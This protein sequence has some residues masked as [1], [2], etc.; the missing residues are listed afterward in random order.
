MR[1]K[2]LSTLAVAVLAVGAAA[3]VPLTASAAEDCRTIPVNAD[4][5][6]TSD[7][8]RADF[9]VDGTGIKVGIISGSFNLVDTGSTWEQ[10][11]AQGLL[12][13]E[14]NPC[15]WTT[16]VVRLSEPDTNVVPAS[17]ITDEGRAMAQVV[18]GIAPGAEL[19]YAEGVGQG[20]AQ[21]IQQLR[22][23]GVDIIV[24]DLIAADETV[25]QVSAQTAAIEEAVASGVTYLTAAG[26]NT[27]VSLERRRTGNELVPIGNWETVAYRPAPCDPS[28]KVTVTAPFTGYDC[29]DFD[30]TEGVRT[31][32]SLV[33][34]PAEL[35]EPETVAQPTVIMQWAEP[36]GAA[37][38]AFSIV[39]TG[40]TADGTVIASD[41]TYPAAAGRI[42]INVPPIVRDD[43]PANE[44]TVGL[45]IVRMTTGTPE[46][47]ITPALRLVFPTDGP[48]WIASSDEVASNELDTVGR[49]IVGH[50]A[51]PSALTVA[52]TGAGDE[53][54][55]EQFSSL[56]PAS[57]VYF[58]VTGA[59]VAD[60]RTI[61]KPTI[62][63][64]DGIEQNALT[65]GEEIQ[66]GV[67]LFNGTSAAT[68]SA[69][70]VAAL[71]LQLNP[72]L[73]PAE[74]GR[75]IEQS[76]TPDR[77]IYPSIAD[78]DAVGSGLVNAQALLTAV[79]ATL[80]APQPGEAPPRPT[81]AASGLTDGG[82]AVPLGLVLLTLGLAVVVTVRVRR[83]TGDTR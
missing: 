36:D 8:A 61:S 78:R 35:A 6:L 79:Q 72:A 2:I 41:P 81:L 3:A 17:L 30:A 69:G 68:P 13:G 11:I 75:L 16:P 47:D 46:T 1:T 66:P 77:S 45:S 70:A 19:F 57:P 37:K 53:G 23:A 29:M 39:A 82:T 38:A 15:G 51:A 55:L 12:P 25:Y 83:K 9:G 67:W 5:E 49:S 43:L 10:N 31:V 7:I 4:S 50:N 44:V 28:V 60:P 42:S 40:G 54:Q 34:V 52:A 18:H 73:T 26:N 76:T 62:L 24:D 71:A 56:G 21:A 59:P 63:S 58:D 22:G 48:Q 74:L 32:S 14:G 33:T 80:P 64:V 27:L 20:L 65:E